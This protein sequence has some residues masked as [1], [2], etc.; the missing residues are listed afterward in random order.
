MLYAKV[1]EAGQTELK[2]EMKQTK[3]KKW[4]RRLKIIDLSGQGKSVPELTRLFELSGGTI[5]SYIKAY[6]D[7]GLAGLQIKHGQGRPLSLE[8]TQTQWQDLIHQAPRDYDK[9]DSAAMNWN[10]VIRYIMLS[11]MTHNILF[12]QQCQI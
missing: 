1:D 6:N 11:Q 5:R 8:W 12:S 3:E 10:Q 4:Y 7:D 2:R 9:L